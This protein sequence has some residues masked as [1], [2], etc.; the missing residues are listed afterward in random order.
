MPLTFLVLGAVFA[1]AL[2]VSLIATPAAIALARRW[3]FMAV[4]GQVK[5]IHRIPV[6]RLGGLPLFLGFMFA[7]AFALWTSPLVTPPAGPDPRE[8]TRL[9]GLILGATVAFALGVLDDRVEL[10]PNPQFLAAGIAVY[11]GIRIDAIANPLGGDMLFFPLWLSV[12]L[13]F[14][15]IVLAMNTINW[16]DGLDG[17]AAGIGAIAAII[18]FLRSVT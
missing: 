15:W 18:L 8:P 12:P 16:L 5:H 17:L 7:V 9:V 3:G 10:S 2:V 14:F 6:P 11:F 13:T 4:P 1:I